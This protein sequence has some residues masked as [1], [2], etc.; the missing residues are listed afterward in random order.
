[1]ISQTK[2]DL[3]TAPEIRDVMQEFHHQIFHLERS[4]KELEAALLEE[5]DDRDYLFAILENK[6][7]IALKKDSIERMEE[8]LR[9]VDMAF[10]KEEVAAA[11]QGRLHPDHI[12]ISLSALAIAEG[13]AKD[14]DDSGSAE[15]QP[16][17]AEQEAEEERA[18]PTEGIFL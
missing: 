17:A 10:C 12:D 2:L 1:M 3:M 16:V 7:T 18:Q 9:E 14:A 5:P 8:R 6:E 11:R 15:Q 4:Q 13:E